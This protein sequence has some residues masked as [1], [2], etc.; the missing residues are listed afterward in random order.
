LIESRGWSGEWGWTTASLSL[1]EVSCHK[2]CRKCDHS[3]PIFIVAQVSL[4]PV[5]GSGTSGVFV[6]GQELFP[7]SVPVPGPLGPVCLSLLHHFSQ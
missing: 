6:A 5:S 7:L 2:K 4:E 1:E 3:L